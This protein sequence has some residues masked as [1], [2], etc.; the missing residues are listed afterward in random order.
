MK[1]IRLSNCK[2]FVLID[3]APN[4]NGEFAILNEMEEVNA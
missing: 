4:N 2:K 3:A 1:Q